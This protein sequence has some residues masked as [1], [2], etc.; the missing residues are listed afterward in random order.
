MG[1]LV[2]IFDRIITA[3][4]VREEILSHTTTSLQSTAAP[5]DSN[6]ILG[7][8]L[9]QN[10]ASTKDNRNNNEDNNEY[11]EDN[12][13]EQA[14]Q[15][16]SMKKMDWRAFLWC[17]YA[18]L[19]RVL[20]TEGHPL[21]V[22]SPTNSN[23]LI[24]KPWPYQMKGNHHHH[25]HNSPTKASNNAFFLSN[26]S[27]SY[28]PI[29]DE[30]YADGQ[31]H[32]VW[33]CAYEIIS[34]AGSPPPWMGVNHVWNAVV[35]RLMPIA[36]LNQLLQRSENQYQS[37]TSD[38]NKNN[39]SDAIGDN[40]YVGWEIVMHY[41]R[42]FE[43]PYN[44]AEQSETASTFTPVGP[45]KPMGVLGFSSA[46]QLELFGCVAKAILSPSCPSVATRTKKAFIRHAFELSHSFVYSGT[47]GLAMQALTQ[48]DLYASIRDILVI[49]FS[50]DVYLRSPVYILLAQRV[51]LSIE[52]IPRSLATELKAKVGA[53]FSG[54]RGASEND[55]SVSEENEGVEAVKKERKV[56]KE[57]DIDR[58][59]KEDSKKS[60][61]SVSS[62]PQKESKVDV[63][64]PP[65]HLHHPM[66]P[67]GM[68]LDET[69][70]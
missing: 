17:G 26:T 56:N 38:T 68:S 19:A 50:W 11:Q 41:G 31:I 29:S 32:K 61:H 64:K 48:G 51:G 42:Q 16:S 2:N 60:D 35:M 36:F 21:C 46:E 18:D 37:T 45:I 54:K 33:Q 14:N 34:L 39:K 40:K 15:P 47:D 49:L 69:I 7:L 59:I 20:L 27:L 52:T 4:E 6:T 43:A 8:I 24:S 67:V 10:S 13:L 62:S 66:S 28:F 44:E 3:Q 55:E 58:S 70:E 63:T 30:A 57:K 25:E 1:A 65:Q 53:P 22:R 23:V 5:D 12:D 9:G